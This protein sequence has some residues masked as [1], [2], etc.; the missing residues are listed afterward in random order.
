MDCITI[1]IAQASS[2]P[3]IPITNSGQQ[4]LGLDWQTIIIAVLTGTS[5]GL[6]SALLTP[7]SQL[8]IDI[9]KDE[10]KSI[11]ITVEH[12]QDLIDTQI[13]IRYLMEAMCFQEFIL[14]LNSSIKRELFRLIDEYEEQLKNL[15]DAETEVRRKAKQDLEDE[16][17]FIEKET[18]LPVDDSAQRGL[19]SERVSDIIFEK[20][21]ELAK[22][23]RVFL[24]K[25][26]AILKKKWSL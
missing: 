21:Q 23:L 20:K 18:H 16:K 5:A 7:W 6:L 11:R 22:P 13:E 14:R 12:L 4:A 10:R 19:L 24:A 2:P 3:P 26:I 1:F 17:N 15:L 9:K 25:Q 8:A